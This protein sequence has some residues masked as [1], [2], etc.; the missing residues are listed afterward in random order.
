MI[1]T[2][3][4]N[5]PQRNDTAAGPLSL[6]SNRLI[7]ELL[8]V[9]LSPG[10]I[11]SNRSG[12][13]PSISALIYRSQLLTP[14]CRLWKADCHSAYQKVSCFL[15]GTRRFITVLAKVHNWTLS[16]ASWIYFALSIPISL[17]HS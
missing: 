12:P 10:T 13:L 8:M 1:V 3:K 7:T 6:G 11:F 17:R 14:W 9:F 2:M 15:Y 5:Q 4:Q 16:W